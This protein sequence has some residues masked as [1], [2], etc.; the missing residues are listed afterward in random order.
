MAC[1][2][3]SQWHPAGGGGARKKEGVAA[4]CA[5]LPEGYDLWNP[6]SG[7]VA[8]VSCESVTL[9]LQCFDSGRSILLKDLFGW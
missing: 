2:A 5:R 7:R 6:I 9:G 3:A 8:A 1:R 4:R